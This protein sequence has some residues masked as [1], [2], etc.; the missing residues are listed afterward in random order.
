MHPHNRWQ[1]GW[2]EHLANVQTEAE[3]GAVLGQAARQLGFESYAIGMR[4][5]LPLSN[6]KIIT[7]NDYAP[8]WRERYAAA[9]YLGVDPT[10]AHALVSTRP[11]LW[12][13]QVFARAQDFWD[14]AHGHGL[15]I[16]WAQPA[17]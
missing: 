16:G 11:V 7:L 15:R 12:S 8:A 17:C 1:Q 6:P 2:Q 3:L 14:D 4:L 5:P 10:V 9:L 13:D